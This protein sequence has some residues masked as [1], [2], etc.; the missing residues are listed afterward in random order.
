MRTCTLI[1]LL[2]ALMLAACQ[3]QILD[4]GATDEPLASAPPASTSV[5]VATIASAA[6]TSTPALQAT[7]PPEPT[8]T[9]APTA[10]PTSLA[11]VREGQAILIDH[12]NIDR[13]ENIPDQYIQ[14]ASQM[15]L[16]LLH[17]SVGWNISVSLNCMGDLQPRVG[18]CH[19]TPP[20][21]EYRDAKYNW[22]NWVFDFYQPPPAQNPGWYNKVSIFINRINAAAPDEKYDVA[23]F[24]LGYVDALTGSE[25]ADEF[26]KVPNQ[27]YPTIQDIEE[28]E[29]QHPETTF[30]YTTLV[31]ARA[32]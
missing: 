26:F 17:A 25:I 14:A 29:L 15:R 1:F 19:V 3:P 5:P 2:L 22:S 4:T 18:H 13:F 10:S 6:P 20:Q 32:V 27:V 28:L 23:T 21:K 8:A 12:T 31:L 9:A 24:K 7:T 16:F 30:V 11:S